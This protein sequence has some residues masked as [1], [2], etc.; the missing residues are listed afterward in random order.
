MSTLQEIQK[1]LGALQQGRID[2]ETAL[3]GLRDIPYELLGHTRL[4]HH[5]SL[6]QGVPEVV[7]CEGK[8]EAQIRE[9][10]IRLIKR[11]GELLATRVP[12]RLARLLCRKFP[13]LRYDPLGRTL[14]LV[15]RPRKRRVGRVLILTAGTSDIP[16]AQEA[17]R[18][19]ETL[20]SQVKIAFDVGVAGI[21]R[22]ADL[23]RELKAARV[24]VVVAGMDGALPS[25]VGGLVSQPVI[26]VPTSTGYGASF[27]GLSA[28]LAML[29]SCAAGLAVVNIDNGF[30][31]GCLA[32]KINFL[33]ER[34]TSPSE[35]QRK[36]SS[37]VLR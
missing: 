13:D 4:D 25:V 15:A 21:H 28:L 11:K 3:E 33:P 12:A 32:H 7:F 16:V 1:L 29:N 6:R 20:G 30:G 24:I 31:A 34:P 26:A 9:I 10:I 35:P 27:G 19:A 5:R 8:S 22:L 2:P 23:R 37:G 36:P 17:R 18:T 14:S